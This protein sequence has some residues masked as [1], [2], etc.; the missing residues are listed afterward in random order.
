MSLGSSR[1]RVFRSGWLGEDCGSAGEESNN[2]N[3]KR[4]TT[5]DQVVLTRRSK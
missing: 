5:S 3:N 1:E 4:A 2:N